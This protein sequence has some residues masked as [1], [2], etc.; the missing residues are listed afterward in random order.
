MEMS[1]CGEKIF[2]V[3]TLVKAIHQAHFDN[4]SEYTLHTATNESK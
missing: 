4:V 2:C 3:D 1:E